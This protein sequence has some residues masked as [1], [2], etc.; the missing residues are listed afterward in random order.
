MEY[1][2]VIAAA[3]NLAKST[4]CTIKLENIPVQRV[5]PD[6]QKS[7]VTYGEIARKK[8]YIGDSVSVVT[9]YL[10]PF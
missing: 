6:Y 1:A 8:F 3:E 5:P 9:L 7:K 2:E 4:V 10:L